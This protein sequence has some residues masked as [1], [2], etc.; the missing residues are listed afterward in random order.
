MRL[1]LFLEEKA[2][3]QTVFNDITEKF[4][5]GPK[6]GVINDTEEGSQIEI[7]QGPLSKIEKFVREKYQEYD[8][9]ITDGV[10]IMV[11]TRTS[12]LDEGIQKST[13]YG[14]AGPDNVL[15]AKGNKKEMEKLRKKKGKGY[16]IW[17]TP[18]GK[19]GDTMK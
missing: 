5:L 9:K 14:L 15:I 8:T 1:K 3:I 6:A 19:V 7:K 18:G 4:E 17:N 10:L 16:R 12:G 11:R 2:D 13:M